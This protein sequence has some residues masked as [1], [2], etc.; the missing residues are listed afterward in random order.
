MAWHG[1]RFGGHER[2][3]WETAGYSLAA[4]WRP[5]TRALTD[6]RRLARRVDAPSNQILGVSDQRKKRAQAPQGPACATH[7]TPRKTEA[8]LG[9]TAVCGRARC[10]TL[11]SVMKSLLACCWYKYIGR[12]ASHRTGRSLR[13]LRR[14]PA[15]EG[16][17]PSRKALE[18]RAPLLLHYSVS[19]EAAMARNSSPPWSAA[20]PLAPAPRALANARAPSS[21]EV[22]VC[23]SCS[24]ALSARLVAGSQPSGRP[25]ARVGA[26][27]GGEAAAA[28]Q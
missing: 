12:Y 3:R 6:T 28:A 13:R 4:V 21:F 17:C 24:A 7:G 10:G 14:R 15:G 11:R 26:A 22:G 20:R 5:E 9:T 16:G 19:M 1:R 8:R 27:C 25:A 23:M 2:Y 18:R